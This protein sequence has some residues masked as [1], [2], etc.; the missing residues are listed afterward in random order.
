MC[1]EF[2]TIPCIQQKL[3]TSPYI[4][5]QRV[6]TMYDSCS[7]QHEAAAAKIMEETEKKAHKRANR[8]YIERMNVVHEHDTFK[9]YLFL[10]Q[11]ECHRRNKNAYSLLR[12]RTDSYLNSLTM[13]YT[14]TKNQFQTN[15]SR[16]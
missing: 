13:H 12:R 15:S 3:N 2:Y 16:K 14:H 9:F 6:T 4:H 11:I 8:T 5:I 10:C 1:S 7:Q